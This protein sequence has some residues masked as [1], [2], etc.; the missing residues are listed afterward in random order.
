[1]PPGTRGPQSHRPQ[2][3]FMRPPPAK[4][5]SAAL[6]L[7]LAVA[8]LMT[9]AGMVMVARRRRALNASAPSLRG[10]FCQA[11]Q[12]DT[13][14]HKPRAAPTSKRTATKNPNFRNGFFWR[15]ARPARGRGQCREGG[16]ATP[17]SASDCRSSASARIGRGTA[18]SRLVQAT[19]P[20]GDVQNLTTRAQE[21]FIWPHLSPPSQ[22]P[23]PAPRK[24]RA[25][26]CPK[27]CPNIFTI[28]ANCNFCGADL[29]EDFWGPTRW[30]FL[31]KFRG[32]DAGAQNYPQ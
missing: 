22:K 23:L 16:F 10:A 25:K 6:G 12:R 3:L 13:S 31:W 2:S 21:L 9:D 1:M 32:A 17:A 14:A 7:I 24:A 27:N 30:R 4:T 29:G 11:S 26:T 20:K 8:A 5:T 15:E 28:K 18:A 19:M